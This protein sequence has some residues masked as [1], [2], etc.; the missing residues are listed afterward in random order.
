MNQIYCVNCKNYLPFQR[1]KPNEDY[2]KCILFH[3]ETVNLITGK[4]SRQYTKNS[5]CE[6]ARKDI[7]ACGPEGKFYEEKPVEI[8]VDNSMI[9]KLKRWLKMF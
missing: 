6:Y 3:P 9:G 5:W 7:N 8:K 4:V 2:D 1:N